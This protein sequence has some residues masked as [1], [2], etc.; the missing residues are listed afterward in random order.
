MEQLAKITEIAMFVYAHNFI[1]EQTVNYIQMHAL[2]AHAWTVLLVRYLIMVLH[3]L[4]PVHL[5]TPEQ[6]VKYITYVLTTL[7]WM[8]QLVN[9][10]EQTHTFVSVHL[11]ILEQIA[12][13]TIHVIIVHVWMEVHVN[14]MEIRSYVFVLYSIPDQT[15]KLTQMLAHLNLV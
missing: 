8:V 6:I 15:V 1:Q 12:R 4:A 2:Q 9:H 7:V 10:L 3:I 14:Q 11:V 13:F 5:A